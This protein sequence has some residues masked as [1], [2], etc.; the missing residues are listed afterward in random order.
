MSLDSQPLR[1]EVS[2]H[3]DKNAKWT[4]TTTPSIYIVSLDSQPLRLEVSTHKDKNGK[5]TLTTTPSITY[6]IISLIRFTTIETRGCKSN[7]TI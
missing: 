5:W 4:L 6:S 7:D 2:T 1:L 3:K